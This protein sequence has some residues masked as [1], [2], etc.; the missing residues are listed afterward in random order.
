MASMPAVAQAT[1][2]VSKFVKA[3]TTTSGDT[4]TSAASHGRDG[5]ISRTA[6]TTTSQASASQNA[7]MLK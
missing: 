6:Q 5:R 4:A 3:C 7:E 1:A 2:R